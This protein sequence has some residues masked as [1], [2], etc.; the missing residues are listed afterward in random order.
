MTT[1]EPTELGARARMIRRRRGLSRE[2]TAGLAGISP[3]R[4]ARLEDGRRGFHR[5]ALLEDLATALGCSVT[6]LTGQPYLPAD[7]AGAD[8][9]ATLPDITASLYDT[10]LDDVPDVPARPVQELVSWAA[11]ANEHCDRIAPQRIRNDP[12]AR[13]LLLTLGLR[14][15]RQAAETGSLRN[16]F[17]VAR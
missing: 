15:R 16:R 8:A 17:G 2:V 4:L 3:S 6:D 5:W 9:L 13:D 12:L 7:R 14:A 11:R 10:S 1:L